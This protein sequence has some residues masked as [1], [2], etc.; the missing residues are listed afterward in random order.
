MRANLFIVGAAKSGTTSLASYLGQHQDIFV[1][2]IKEPKYFSLHEN[3]FPHCG[4]GDTVV[5]SNVVK[6][7]SEY[8]KLYIGAENQ[9]Y[10]VDASVDYLFCEGAAARI[11]KYNNKARIIIIL[12]NPVD[13]A[14]SAY[15]HM[16]R[17]GRE[18][19]SFEDALNKEGERAEN[20]WEFF[21][22]YRECGMY[23]QQVKRYYKYFPSSQINVVTFDELARNADM[24]IDRIMSFLE[25]GRAYEIDTS[26]RLNESGIPKNRLLHTLFNKDNSIKSIIKRIIPAVIRNAIK[27]KVTEN[28]LS[29]Q[30]MPLISRK[31]LEGYYDEDVILLEKLLRGKLHWH[32]N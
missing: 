19:L 13:R 23:Y 21:W 32:K 11:W 1:P 20:N 27:D 5:D 26:R 24:L 10:R 17:D 16:V 6:T 7:A 9:I 4:P 18:V 8:K 14:Y 22:R 15:M 2:I 3:I 28:N 25:I 31:Y 29:K 12:R 30:T